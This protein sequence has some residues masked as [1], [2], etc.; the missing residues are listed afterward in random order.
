MFISRTTNTHFRHLSHHIKKRKC[1]CPREIIQMVNVIAFP[2]RST[3]NP[4][5][6]SL[7]LDRHIMEQP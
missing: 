3:L 5:R 1:F 6:V 2:L 4:N 7:E